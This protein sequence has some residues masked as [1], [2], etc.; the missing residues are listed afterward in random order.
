VVVEMLANHNLGADLKA[1]AR[2]GRVVV[3]GSRGTTTIDPRDVMTRE[4][5][6]TGF[7]LFNAPPDAMVPRHTHIHVHTHQCPPTHIHTDAHAHRHRRTDPLLCSR[8]GGPV[9]ACVLTVMA[10]RGVAGRG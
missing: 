2:G 3:V 5:T 6:V 4:L 9:G 10:L 7:L 8:H 1:A